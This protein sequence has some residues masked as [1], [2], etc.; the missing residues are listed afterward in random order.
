M[1]P[2]FARIYRY[3]VSSPG[4]PPTSQHALPL[5]RRISAPLLEGLVAGALARVLAKCVLVGDLPELV[6]RIDLPSDHIELVFRTRAGVN[7]ELAF[8]DMQERLEPAERLVWEDRSQGLCRIRLALTPR[9]RGGRT[10]LDGAPDRPRAARTNAGLVQGLKAAHK[11]LL[12]CLAALRGRR[13]QDRQSARTPAPASTEPAGIPCP[14]SAA[15]D[16][17]RCAAGEPQASHAS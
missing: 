1:T 8:G 10:W 2:T 4:D 11:E 15:P 17:G 3:Y 13:V 9:L 6:T 12:N 5:V 7:A 14:G 16:S